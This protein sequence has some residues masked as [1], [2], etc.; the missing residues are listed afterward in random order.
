MH[1]IMKLNWHIGR[2]MWQ[3][4][5]DWLLNRLSSASGMVKDGFEKLAMVLRFIN[6]AQKILREHGIRDFGSEWQ[7]KVDRDILE[8]EMAHPE[9][10]YDA[11]ISEKHEEFRALM[12]GCAGFFRYHDQLVEYLQS[13]KEQLHQ[14]EIDISSLE[15]GH[16]LARRATLIKEQGRLGLELH[17][18][19]KYL[20]TLIPHVND[21][22]VAL[23]QVQEELRALK[24]EKERM[25]I[26]NDVVA[27][28]RQIVEVLRRKGTH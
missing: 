5:T 10:V 15:E 19:Q 8:L 13:L 27:M 21:A 6:T 14:T 3:N 12:R 26:L 1:H 4:P 23:A 25:L 7:K 16:E 22:K 2:S 18:T 28:R 24:V 11:R 17:T 20:E 9:L